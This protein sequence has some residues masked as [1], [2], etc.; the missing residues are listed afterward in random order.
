VLNATLSGLSIAEGM[1]SLAP[2][3]NTDIER[4]DSSARL[5]S[6]LSI[7]SDDDTLFPI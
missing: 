6:V 5:L 4:T 3:K 2:T 1:N 7:A